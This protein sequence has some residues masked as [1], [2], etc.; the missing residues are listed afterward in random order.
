MDCKVVIYMQKVTDFVSRK[1]TDSLQRTEDSTAE[2]SQ[3]RKQL[4]E[5]ILRCSLFLLHDREKKQEKF[6]KKVINRLVK[7]KDRNKK[8][9]N[10]KKR[11]FRF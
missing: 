1:K 6:N 3:E 10:N 8:V 7:L 2:Y 5:E 11:G 4:I 9:G